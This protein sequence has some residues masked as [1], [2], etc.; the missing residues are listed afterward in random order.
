MYKAKSKKIYKYTAFFEPAE[1]GG[2]VVTMP[3]RQNIYNK[4][5]AAYCKEGRQAHIQRQKILRSSACRRQD[6]LEENI[7]NLLLNC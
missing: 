6:N 1:E 5:S 7:F 2:Y 4:T 3:G